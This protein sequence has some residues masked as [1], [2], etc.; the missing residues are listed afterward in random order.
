MKLV[1]FGDLVEVAHLLEVGVADQVVG[2]PV[3]VAFR[4]NGGVF[5]F[6]SGIATASQR[7]P[8]PDHTTHVVRVAETMCERHERMLLQERVFG[9]EHMDRDT[10][11]GRDT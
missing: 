3:R 2:V 8:P 7:C 1:L 5:A 11:V 6:M 4:S 10:F 9:R